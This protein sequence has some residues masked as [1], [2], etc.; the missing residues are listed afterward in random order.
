MNC[1]C[2]NDNHWFEN[3]LVTLHT[4]RK[5]RKQHYCCECQTTIESGERYKHTS[6]LTRDREWYTSKTCLDCTSASA[7]VCS[8]TVGQMWTEIEDALAEAPDDGIPWGV[9]AEL[10]P[11]ARAR[12]CEWI[13]EMWERRYGG[14]TCE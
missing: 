4:V 8:W 9:I 1:S 10:T 6:A 12:V 14:E 5:A 2:L 3:N 11:G 13:E 7:L